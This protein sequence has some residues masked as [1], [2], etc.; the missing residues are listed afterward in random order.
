MRRSKTW[1]LRLALAGAALSLACSSSNNNA[2][3]SAN[4]SAPPTQAAATQ[5][6]AAAATRSAASPTAASSQPTG[7]P[8]ATGGN[9]TAA[10]S[11]IAA[12]QAL[13][14]AA[15][16]GSP[17]DQVTISKPV[18][19]NFWEQIPD[20]G[21]GG[22]KLAALIK[23]FQSKNPNIT[24]NAQYIG[25][26][27]DLFQKNQTA[28]VGG[29]SPDL[30]VA[31]G[32]EVSNYQQANVIVPLDDY[33]KSQKYGLTKDDYTDILQSYRYDNFYPPYGN[34][35]LT[36]PWQK[37]VELLYYNEDL[38]K[39]ANVA[40]PQTWDDFV[41]A[42]KAVTNG[43]AKGYA[44]GIDASRIATGVYSR[45]GNLLSDDQKK[46]VFNNDAGVAQIALYQQ[47]MKDGSAYQLASGASNTND[48]VA[49]KTVFFNDSSSHLTQ[50][51]QAAQ[52][53]G[54]VHWGVAMPVHGTGA[55]AVTNMYGGNITVF[56][57][58]P[59]KQLAAWLFI[60]YFTSKE[61]NPDWS[62]ATGYLPI[63]TSGL[64]D[65]RIKAAVQAFPQFG[66]A[67]QAQ[68]YGRPEP[69]VRQWNAIR[70]I[71]QD[72][73]VAA[74]NDPNK[75][76]KAIMDDAVSKANDALSQ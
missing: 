5:T 16:T 63:R 18:T 47:L 55:P 45:G 65:D 27:A 26:Y 69:N 9:V 42:A 11:V 31:Y 2:G 12:D 33:I 22:Q 19:L 56:K 72:A 24:I 41:K 40:V 38:L 28:I 75:S 51:Q 74:I 36:F 3:K 50:V 15:G 70:A 10:P 61:V 44:I 67:L 7:S 34:K 57:T 6:A 58:T 1:I 30:S 20:N 59:E 76:A 39:A 54:G 17:V 37:S 14:A 73:M 23:D 13:A 25:P 46:A 29:Q 43:S 49:G 53:Q 68:Q 71:L 21:P 35:M 52:Q 4:T 66:V 62:I 64:N 32:N 48:M 8:T 60:K